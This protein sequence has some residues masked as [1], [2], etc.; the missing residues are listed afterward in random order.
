MAWVLLERYVIS[1]RELGKVVDVDAELLKIG[2]VQA[3]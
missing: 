1:C 3:L 2:N